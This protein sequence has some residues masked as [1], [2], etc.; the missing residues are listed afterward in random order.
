MTDTPSPFEV[1]DS[2]GLTDDD[3]ADIQTLKQLYESSGR[4]AVLKALGELGASDP[5]RSIRIL[6]ALFPKTVR[7]ALK[8]SL[9]EEG[10]TEDDL[11]GLILKHTGKN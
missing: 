4:D 9:A 6:H 11:K 3:Q 8:D 2:S 10:I 7:E 5:V 1:V